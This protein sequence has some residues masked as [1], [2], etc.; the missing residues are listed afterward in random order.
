ME[1]VTDTEIYKYKSE[2]VVEIRGVDS[3]GNFTVTSY[4]FSENVD[5]STVQPKGEFEAQYKGEIETALED[6]GYI[7]DES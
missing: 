6:A 3:D 1:N 5:G 7:L 4:R 2:V